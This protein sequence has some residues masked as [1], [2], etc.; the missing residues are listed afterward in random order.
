MIKVSGLELSHTVF[1]DT[2][3]LQKKLN[4]SKMKLIFIAVYSNTLSYEDGSF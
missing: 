4:V 3:I 2:L 1:S